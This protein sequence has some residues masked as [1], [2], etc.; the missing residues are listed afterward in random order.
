MIDAHDFARKQMELTAEFG[1]Y[2]VDHPEVDE[3]LPAESYIY[4]E[5]EG[6]DEFNC[7]SR[8]LA[9]KQLRDEGLPIVR[10][11]VKGLTPPQGS[12]LS[13]PVIEPMPAL[14]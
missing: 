14:A 5:V 4:F 12:R 13:D 11:R 8:E 1:Q 6:E 10:V 3:T 9:E 2:V 7:F